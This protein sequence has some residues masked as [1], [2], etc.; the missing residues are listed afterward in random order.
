MQA[1]REGLALAIHWCN[2]PLL[3]EVDCVEIVLI[4]RKGEVDRSVFNPTVEETNALL[5]AHP[6]C[7]THINRFQSMCSHFF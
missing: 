7:V 1:I 5:K 3:I 2:N 4:L 6:S